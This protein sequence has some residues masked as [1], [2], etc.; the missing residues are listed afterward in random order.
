M[1]CK[2]VL[3]REEQIVTNWRVWILTTVAAV[4]GAYVL[5]VTAPVRAASVVTYTLENAELA[6]G[7]DVTGSIYFDV[8][9][10]EITGAN[11]NLVNPSDGDVLDEYT[12]YDP[13][14]A[15]AH[16]FSVV[17][18]TGGYVTEIT[19]INDLTGGIGDAEY[20]NNGSEVFVP[21]GGDEYINPGASVN[22]GSAGPSSVPGSVPEPS[23]IMATV[24]AV[25]LGVVLRRKK[26]KV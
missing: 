3:P 12:E 21:I 8:A 20:L 15:T 18:Q 17:P 4:G 1:R 13:G 25:T 19:L 5:G 22:V 10:D 9:N 2:Q 26:R 11:L 24:T 6:D 16:S 23:S 7:D 14:D